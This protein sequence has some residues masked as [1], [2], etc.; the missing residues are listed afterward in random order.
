[1]GDRDDSNVYIRMKLK[2]AAEVGIN[3]N[4]IK[5]PSTTTQ[6]EVSRLVQKCSLLYVCWVDPNIVTPVNKY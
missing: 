6:Y 1:V 2:A 4:H 5:L 3:A